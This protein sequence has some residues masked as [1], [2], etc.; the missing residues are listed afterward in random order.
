MDDDEFERYANDPLM[1]LGPIVSSLPSTIFLFGFV[2]AERLLLLFVL[3]F[4]RASQKLLRAADGLVGEQIERDTEELDGL[5]T[6]LRNRP[7]RI[8]LH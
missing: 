7:K 3:A 4:L 6:E 1:Y 5:R 8:T 2:W